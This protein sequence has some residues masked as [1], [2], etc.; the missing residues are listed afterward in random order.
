MYFNL[1]RILRGLM[2][3][4]FFLSSKLLISCEG[5]SRSF[6]GVPSHVVDIW[7]ARHVSQQIVFNHVSNT[8]SPINDVTAFTYL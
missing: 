3:F 5:S 8:P 7:S 4:Y 1:V 6:C 2:K